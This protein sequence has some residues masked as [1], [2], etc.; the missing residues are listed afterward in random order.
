VVLN[1]RT[2]VAGA[3]SC[4]VV[5]GALSAPVAAQAAQAALPR[6]LAGS[7]PYTALSDGTLVYVN[8]ANLPPADI[9][10]VGLGQS[11][12]GVAVPSGLGTADQLKQ[13]LLGKP[14]AGKTAYGH[15]TGAG[16]GLLDSLSAPPAIDLTTAEATSPAPSTATSILANIPLS[17][18]AT[19]DVTPS[20][21]TANTTA[22]GSCVI[23]KDISN[24]AAHIAN[25]QALIAA[26]A[27]V[28][29]LGGTSDTTSRTRL[30]TPTKANGS[31]VTTGKSGL[32]AQTTQTL[33]PITLFKGVAGAETTITVLG[34][35]QLSAAAGGVPGTSVVSYGVVGKGDADPVV[36]IKNGSNTQSL[37]SQQVFTGSGV[38][39]KLG[40]ADVTIGTPAHSLTGLEGTPVTQA[41]NGTNASAAVDFVRVTV[42]GSLTPNGSAVGGP[43]GGVL[44][45]VLDPVAAALAPLTDQIKSALVSAGL[46]VA[47]VRVGHLESRATVPVGGIDCSTENPLSES[48]KDVT[49]LNVQP[50]STFDYDIRVPNRGTSPITNVK[51]VDTYPAELI[52]VSSVPAPSSRSGNTLTFNLGTLQ[53]NEFRTIQMVFKVPAGAKAGTVYRNSAII[54]GTYQGQPISFPVAVDGPTV[55]P[56]HTGDCNL[57]G[58]TKFASN[59][60][61]KTGENF[62]YFVNVLNSG[63]KDCAN[64]KVSDTLINGVRFVSCT[65][66]C[67]HNG[68]VVTWKLGTLKAGSSR[69]VAVIVKVVATSGTLPNTAIVTSPSGPGG[70]PSTVGPTITSASVPAPGRPADGPDGANGQLPRTGLPAGLGALGLMGL[71]GAG[72]MMRLRRRESI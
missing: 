63:G 43:L 24:G 66:G 12:A 28:V 14:T 17:P 37:T 19:A 51:V 5:A 22:D 18:L 50:G 26:P 60:R 40:V 48:R 68:Q 55:G 59:T 10:K 44:N 15:G 7:S 29:D 46:G 3:L 27:T 67:T 36:T 58:S 72:A 49:A 31:T 42:P 23:G 4:L 71:L 54:T 6:A 8:A 11:A 25:A 57:S 61:V 21:A 70:R 33:A 30:V 16:V 39:I 41:A 47:D 9:A 45:P 1:S 52:F 13:P 69:V 53:P 65:D 56:V 64:V 20:S 2:R 35:L 32:L 62:G 38:V 34:P